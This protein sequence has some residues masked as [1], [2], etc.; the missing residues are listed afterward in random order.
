MAVEDN[1][2]VSSMNDLKN[3]T[4]HAVLG[5][6]AYFFGRGVFLVPVQNAKAALQILPLSCVDQVE[7]ANRCYAPS[8][9]LSRSLSPAPSPSSND[10]SFRYSRLLP[11]DELK[12]DPFSFLSFVQS[13]QWPPIL[14]EFSLHLTSLL[15][16]ILI[17]SL[18]S[19]V[20]R[21]TLLEGLWPHSYDSYYRRVFVASILPAFKRVASVVGST[22]LVYPLHL[23]RARHV[24]RLLLLG[25]EDETKRFN[26]EPSTPWKNNF[27]GVSC[28]LIHSTTLNLLSEFLKGKVLPTQLPWGSL[29]NQIALTEKG[30]VVEQRTLEC[31]A[32]ALSSFL[33]SPLELGFRRAATRLGGEKGGFYEM[34][35]VYRHGKE[36]RK[37]DGTRAGILGG[38]F[39]LYRGA[40]WSFPEAFVRVLVQHFVY[41]L[42]ARILRARN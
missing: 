28:A 29:A 13:L 26:D 40:S 14:V 16:K 19:Q 2:S 22:T 33:L 18:F 39:A 32:L 31:L 7:V 11:C 1:V 34:K 35:R 20:T 36:R 38:I 12:I 6:T 25:L 37:S 27:R 4:V 8:P 15:S 23:R 41:R 42:A 21:P 5:L 9:F 3:Q 30:G 10:Q 24:D 17:N